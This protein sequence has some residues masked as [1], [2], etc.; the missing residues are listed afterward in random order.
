MKIAIIGSGNMGSA[1]ARRAAAAGHEVTMAAKNEADTK[2]IAQ[3]IGSGVRASPLAGLAEKADLIIAATPYEQQAT[4]IKNAGTVSGKIVVDISNP[5]K[6]DYSGL[7]VGHSTSAAEEIAKALPG[8]KVVKAFNT[9]FAQVLTEGP[10]FGETRRAAVFYAGDDES[11]K[12]T[13]RTLIETMGFE[14]IDAGPLP[15]ARYLEPIGMLNIWFGYMAK[16]G[17]G[18]APTWLRRG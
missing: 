1:L 6:Q 5:V 15:N 7:L 18:I 8:A 9:V 10:D 12:Q 13:V 17:T 11:A 3:D 4:A 14:P 2:K 16:Q